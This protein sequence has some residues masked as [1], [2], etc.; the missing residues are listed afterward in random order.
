MNYTAARPAEP[1]RPVLQLQGHSETLDFVAADVVAASRVR[2]AGFDLRRS[3][4]I[5]IPTGLSSAPDPAGANP[6]GVVDAALTAADPSPRTRRLRDAAAE[7]D[8]VSDY[9]AKVQTEVI[10]Q[11]AALRA[12]NAAELQSTKSNLTRTIIEVLA[13]K[14]AE[15]LYK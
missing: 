5:R 2:R 12:R 1:K 6:V 11:A 13:K 9:A 4:L 8:C 10:T 7:E 14:E 15:N 3:S